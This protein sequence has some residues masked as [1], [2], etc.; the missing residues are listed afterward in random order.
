M[1]RSKE[2]IVLPVWLLATTALSAS[3]HPPSGESD[4]SCH[5]DRPL[6]AISMPVKL[7]AKGGSCLV[8]ARRANSG[9]VLVDLRPRQDFSRFHIP[10]AVNQ[11]LNHLL[12]QRPH[13]AVVYDAGKLTQDAE[14]LCERLQRYGLEDVHVIDGGI[15][16]WTQLNAPQQ[17]LPTS[18]LDDREI[19]SA[20]LGA[21]GQV[22]P[23]SPTFAQV[24]TLLPPARKNGGQTLLLATSEAQIGHHLA[25]RKSG[26]TA[27]YWIGDPSRLHML[28]ENLVAQ[29]RKRELGPGYS[30]TC[31]AL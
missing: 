15:A 9:S 25:E 21:R 24:L 16:A 12:S 19:A 13:G 20:L 1:K 28:L 8:G 31:S 22:I 26:S 17:A 4:L 18:R 29:D 11:Q 6:A 2:G 27:L 30:S 5:K 23:L 3:A 10:G 14:L 7:E